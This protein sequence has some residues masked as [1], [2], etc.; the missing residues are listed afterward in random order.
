MNFILTLNNHFSK[1]WCDDM[2]QYFESNEQLHQKGFQGEN[3]RLENTE[4]SLDVFR[5]NLIDK[6]DEG[7][8][9]YKK[10]YPLISTNIGPWQ[11]FKTCQLMKYTSGQSYS[12]EHCEHGVSSDKEGFKR[13]IAWQINLNTIEDFGGTWFSHFDHTITPIQGSLSFWPAAWTHMHKG[14]V[15]P[16]EDKYI[17][18]GWYNYE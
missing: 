16:K 10:Q 14:L 4:I 18:T 13:V 8:S 2:I 9:Y 5:I 15:A 1:K 12:I 6:I 17:I 7:L 11:I 3:G